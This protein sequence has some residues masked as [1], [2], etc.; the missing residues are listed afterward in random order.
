MLRRI[1]YVNAFWSLSLLHLSQ[2]LSQVV[3]DDVSVLTI[4]NTAHALSNT[5]THTHTHT[6]T[7][8]HTHT[9][10]HTHFPRC[11]VLEFSLCFPRSFLLYFIRLSLFDLNIPRTEVCVS[12]NI[13]TDRVGA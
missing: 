2:S 4:H 5:L 9:H 11:S 12:L 13:W 10:T 7:H 1:T 3:A 6:H 8:P